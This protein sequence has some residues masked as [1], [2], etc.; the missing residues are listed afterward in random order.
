MESNTTFPNHEKVT[1]K[2]WKELQFSP[3]E[4]SIVLSSLLTALLCRLTH[5]RCTLIQNCKT[6]HIS[7]GYSTVLGCHIDAAEQQTALN[8]ELVVS[9]QLFSVILVA[10]N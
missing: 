7:K 3:F 9:N 4:V 8:F 5:A 6:N 2:Y 10:Y 1:T